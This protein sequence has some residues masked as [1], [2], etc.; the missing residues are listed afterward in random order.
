MDSGVRHC[1][2]LEWFL[3]CLNLNWYDD[4]ICDMQLCRMI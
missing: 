4:G 2:V 3:L 1:V